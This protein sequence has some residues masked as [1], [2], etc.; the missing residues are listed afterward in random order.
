M[1]WLLGTCVYVGGRVATY[2]VNLGVHL[3]AAGKAFIMSPVAGD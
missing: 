2:W 1:S 3:K